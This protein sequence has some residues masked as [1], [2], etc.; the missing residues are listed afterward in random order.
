MD[1]CNF[2]LQPM[3]ELS[4]I[5]TGIS[6]VGDGKVIYTRYPARLGLTNPIIRYISS[7][8][9]FLITI[10]CY[11]KFL[12]HVRIIVYHCIYKAFFIF[13]K[14]IRY[15]FRTINLIHSVFSSVLDRYYT[16]VLQPFEMP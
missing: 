1:E 5:S 14:N 4:V 12:D 2:L 8:E 9:K 11:L 16:C 3:W 15:Q 7:Y 6:L 13:V 10:I